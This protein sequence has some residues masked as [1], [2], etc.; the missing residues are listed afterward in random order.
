MLKKLTDK[1][2]KKSPDAEKKR[3]PERRNGFSQESW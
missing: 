2:K 3:N 1:L